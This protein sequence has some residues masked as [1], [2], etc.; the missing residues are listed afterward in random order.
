[1]PAPS[2]PPAQTAPQTQQVLPSY[3]GQNVSSVEIAGDPSLDQNEFLSLLPQKAGEPFAQKKVDASILALNK[4]G[5]F[6]GVQ[7]QVVP[8]IKGVRV[9]LIV[10]PGMYFGMYSFPGALSHFAYSQLLQISNYPPEGPYSIS[11]VNNA[12]AALVRYFQRNGFFLAKVS[13]TLQT[14]RTSGIVNVVFNT[15]LG[16]RAKFGKVSIEGPNPQETADLKGKLH[17]ILARLR[18]SAIREGKT[19]RLKTVQNATTYLQS[20]MSKEAHLAATVKL[21]GANYDPEANRA[22]VAFHVTPGSIINVKVE[23]AHVWSWDKRKFLPVYQE[24]G[25]DPEIIQEGRQ[26]LTSYFQSKGYFDAK[27]NVNVSKQ[28]NND[29]TIVYTIQKGARHKVSDVDVAGNRAL[30]EEELMPSVAVKQ[31]HLFSHGSYSEKLVHQSVKNLEAIYRAAGFSTVKVVPQVKDAGG[32]IDVT[33]MVTEGPRDIIETL[34]ILGNDTMPVAQ[35]APKGLNASPGQ[36]YSQKLVDEDRTNIMA[37]YLESGYLTATFR[38][39]VTTV[40]KDPHRVAVTYKI[41]EGPRVVATN[42]VT[43]GRIQTDQAFINRTA[44]LQPQRPLTENEMLA[45]ESRLYEPQIFDWAEVDPRRQIT[46]QNREEVVVKV[47]EAKRNA[48]AYGFGFEVIKRGGSIPSGTV[49][50]PGI[51][52]VGLSKNFKT[53]EKT[54]YGPRGNFEYT[55]KN[56][57]GRA[58]TLSFGG[59]AGR[60]DQRGNVT[61]Q[62]PHFRLTNWQWELSGTGEHDSTNP[63]F[64]SRVGEASTQFEHPLNADKTQ[65]IFLRYTFSDTGLTRLLSEFQD[66]VPPEDQHVR[67]ST[68]AA[69]YVRDTRDNSLDAH[70]GF[71]QTAEFD[72][73]PSLLGSSVNY[74]KFLG[75]VAYYKKLPAD[76]IIWANSVRIGLEDPFSN[77]HV[78]LAQQFF[79]GGGS[80]LRGFPLD[81]AGPQRQIAICNDP[82]NCPANLTAANC[83]AP[84]CSVTTVPVGGNALA[85][86][87]SEFRIPVPLKQGLGVVAFYDGGNVFRDVTFKGQY[88]NSIGFGIRYAT[89]VGPVRVDIGHLLNA[90]PGVGG[91]QYFITLGQA[92]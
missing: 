49:T 76:N 9:L 61:F 57:F 91:I 65:N 35:L 88:T 37:K 28:A 11:D 18:G 12:S 85:I 5:R 51:P 47:H 81:G 20:A 4:T 78:P 3:E 90:P 21:I 53:A 84:T 59:L 55:R 8:D 56:V 73:N 22:D 25:V 24:V 54:F 17:S 19:Y 64:T 58:E 62:D 34:N 33:F 45:A 83:F 1:M 30:R 14:D 87:N 6:K 40:G 79:S 70:K 43:V 36:P 38:E 48:I 32:N 50:V 29:E 10:Q 77:S 63:I 69:S 66:L 46:T 74:T 42:I 67:L 2:Q 39:T 72:L 23:G 86:L 16:K 41:Y 44:Q 92:F 80:T 15:E 13:P 7:L 26:N 68:V 52:P 75:Q 31:G 89:P 71:Y 27:V 60:L 82:G